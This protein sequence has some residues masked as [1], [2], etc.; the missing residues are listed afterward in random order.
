MFVCRGSRS[1]FASSFSLH[2]LAGSVQVATNIQQDA[3]WSLHNSSIISGSQV[4]NRGA[5]SVYHLRLLNG[6][7]QDESGNSNT[8]KYMSR[9]WTAY[10]SISRLDFILP[11]SWRSKGGNTTD[12]LNSPKSL[13][14][15]YSQTCIIRSSTC[16]LLS[17]ALPNASKQKEADWTKREPSTEVKKVP[18]SKSPR[19]GAEK[20]DP[21]EK[22]NKTKQLKKVFQE[23]GAVG[24]SF[25]IGISLISLG[26]FYIAVSSGINMTDL[27][28][29]LGFSEAVVQSKMAAGTSTF[30]L[31]YAVHKL[32]APVRIS[33]TLVSVPLIV[34]YLRKTGLFKSL[35]PRL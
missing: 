7:L 6:M 14:C 33:I 29:K 4:R 2:N 3:L 35:P 20:P 34:R 15:P 5:D 31:A 22:Q 8:Y 25:H 24:V 10:K 17:S 23:Y 12:L 21:E 19:G 16:D 26:I 32:F 18:L 28:C 30:V 27:L 1:V 13:F 9:S 11:F